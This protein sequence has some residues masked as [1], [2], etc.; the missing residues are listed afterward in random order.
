MGT[1]RKYD[2]AIVFLL[3]WLKIVTDNV[4]KMV[5]YNARKIVTDNSQKIVT[6][7]ARKIVTDNAPGLDS[8]SWDEQRASSRTTKQRWSVEIPLRPEEN[9]NSCNYG[10]VFI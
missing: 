1:S 4:R 3:L 7:N 5:T 2:I 10:T 9:N 8:L 6:D